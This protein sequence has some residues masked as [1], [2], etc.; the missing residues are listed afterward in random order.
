MAGRSQE[1]L[2]IFMRKINFLILLFI[3]SQGTYAQ[4]NGFFT[5]TEEYLEQILEKT[6][7]AKDKIVIKNLVD[8]E[9][10]LHDVQDNHLFTF[11][12]I[13]YNSEIISA[14]ELSVKS[15]WGQALELCKKAE[16]GEANLNN[17]KI[18]DISYLKDI[19]FD[20]DKKTVIFLYSSD[21]KKRHVKKY[22]NT[23][24]NEIKKDPSFDYIVLSLDYPIIVKN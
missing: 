15:C 11:Y 21:L 6:D 2:T 22:I 4:K 8:N 23:I 13:A 17:R 7:F 3:F 24:F 12:G 18:E 9:D 10:F 14:N 16:A 19:P 1:S 20:K 5:T